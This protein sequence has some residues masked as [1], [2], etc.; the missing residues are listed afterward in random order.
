LTN[1]PKGREA[2]LE[3][4]GDEWAYVEWM[5]SGFPLSKVVEKL[6]DYRGVVLAHHGVI[7]WAETSEECLKETHAVVSRAQEFLDSRS[8]TPSAG[9]VVAPDLHELLPVVRGHLSGS[10]K[11]L[12]R[13]DSRLKD[14]ASRP[15]VAILASAGVSSADHM[16]RIRPFSI[17]LEDTTPDGIAAAFERYDLFDNVP[18]VALVP[19]VG[20]LTVGDTLAEAEMLAD[21]ALHT[22]SVAA[23]VMDAFGEVEAMPEPEIFRFEYWPMELYKLGLK[24]G[25][26]K[27]SGQVFV[28]T[29]AAKGIGYAVARHLAALGASLVLAD[30]DGEK[31][32]AVA[33]EIQREFSVDCATVVGDQTQADVVSSTIA[34]AVEAFGGVDGFVANAGIAV[35]GEITDLA[36]EDWN[37]ALNINLTGP[38]L[39]AQAALRVLKS[40]GLGGSLVYMASKNAFA[41]GA[42][43][44]AYSVTKAGIVQLM[45][46][47]AIEA[48]QYGVRSNA[49][50][51]IL[52]CGI[53]ASAKSAPLRTGSSPRNLKSFTPSEI[54]FTAT[55]AA[56]MWRKQWSFYYPTIRA[57]QPVR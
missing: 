1:H 28:V 36:V 41:P 11:R 51:P 52:I 6:G 9:K 4:L 31:L 13:V 10:R 21:I 5:R 37:R 20:A 50:N 8:S 16:L 57:G 32:G 55:S 39:L 22:H 30:I 47:T 14:I 45:R 12:V 33:E 24:P 7:T 49:L 43:F 35:T 25:P 17:V 26:K 23:Q 42:G 19:G 3:A 56:L 18:K 54:C 29:G 38:F 40:Q 44:G 27:F 53:T 46:I 15:D 34:T 2:T 48:G